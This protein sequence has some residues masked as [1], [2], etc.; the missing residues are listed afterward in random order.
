MSVD[1]SRFT[2]HPWKDYFGVVMQQGRVQLDADWNEWVAELARRLQAGAMDTLGPAAAGR[3]VVPSTTPTGFQITAQAGGIMIGVGRVYVDGLLVENHGGPANVWDPRLAEI[4]GT[5]EVSFFEQPYLPFNA[6]S[7]SA[8]ADL[9]NRPGLA[10][11]RHLVYLDVWQREV[12]HLQDPNLVEKAVGVDTTARTQTVWQVRC[13][14]TSG[15]CRLLY[16]EDGELAAGRT[17]PAVRCTPDN[18]TGDV[19]DDPNPCLVAPSA[20]YKGLEKPALSRRDPS[21][22]PAGHGHVQVVA[23]QRHGGDAASPR[24]TAG[25]GSSSTASGATTCSVSTRASGSRSSTIGTSCTDCRAC[26]GGSGPATAWSPRRGRSFSTTDLPQACSRS[27]AQ[28]TTDRRPA[29]TRASLGSVRTVRRA[30]GRVPQPERIERAPT[31]YS[32]PAAGTKLA[33]EDGILIDFSLPV[34]GEFKTGDYWIFTARAPATAVS[35]HSGSGAPA[36]HPSPLRATR[37]RH[38]SGRTGGL[39]RVLAARAGAKAATAR[40]ACTPTRT[41]PA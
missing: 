20:G 23:R 26:C 39:P 8:P 32:V 31:A 33:L 19:P 21:R 34:G 24:S 6:T 15:Q 13:W 16:S 11:G 12:T 29:Y 36:R 38:A 1:C 25:H 41:M 30:D 18:S 7:Q 35:S 27:T 9:F 40:C 14:P 37:H 5:T 2:F 17:G 28:G 4:S 10:G 3:A 22:R